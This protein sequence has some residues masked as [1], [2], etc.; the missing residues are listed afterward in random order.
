MD[1]IKEF[2]Y[3]MTLTQYRY[4]K[5]I[6]YNTYFEQ[7]IENYPDKTYSQSQSY[8]KRKAASELKAKLNKLKTLR[9]ELGMPNVKL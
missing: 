8:A 9:K 2:N 3:L 7:H 1:L 6:L 4:E 5:E